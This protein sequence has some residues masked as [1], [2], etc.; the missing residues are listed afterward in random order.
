MMA[1]PMRAIY[2]CLTIRI[3]FS[4]VKILVITSLLVHAVLPQDIERRLI[5]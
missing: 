5:V 2:Q 1:V 3:P 4:N